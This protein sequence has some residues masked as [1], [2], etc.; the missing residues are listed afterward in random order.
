MCVCGHSDVRLTSPPVLKLRGTQ[1]YLLLP[2][3]LTE[4]I[5]LIGEAFEPKKISLCH[6]FRYYC[7]S[8]RITVIPS[9]LVS[10]LPYL[11]H[12]FRILS[13]FPN[14][15]H[16]KIFVILNSSCTLPYLKGEK[17]GHRRWPCIRVINRFLP[18]LIRKNIIFLL[19]ET[20]LY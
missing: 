14:Y 3:D 5:N 2:Y 9:V 6:S 19:I 12:S 17:N 15:Y 13:F 10:F 20:K 11:C 7:H 8:F 4:V 16:F 18:P 1:G